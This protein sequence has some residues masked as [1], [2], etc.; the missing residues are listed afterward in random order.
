MG[1]S[2]SRLKDQYKELGEQLGLKYKPGV[3]AIL[4]SEVMK[5]QIVYSSG[6]SMS[7][8]QL[9]SVQKVT[10]IFQNP[11]IKKLLEKLFPGFVTGKY[12]DHEVFIYPKSEGEHSSYHMH[13]VLAFKTPFTLGMSIYTES[14][15][16]RVAKSL[17]KAQDIQ[18][19]N[20][21]LDKLVMIKGKDVP[22]VQA[23]L[24][25]HFRQKQLTGFFRKF[26]SSVMDDFGIQYTESSAIVPAL[27]ATEV[28][29][30]L[31][32]VAE[33]FSR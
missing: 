19:G 12:R 17:F 1:V 27:R 16:S 26:P 33:G 18:S 15:F 31:L 2:L 13:F 28:L 4:S 8:Q 32:S 25:D 21:E 23:L 24:S 6:N 9:Q 7:L 10:E 5:R 30:A 11:L 20:A 14:F 3:D 29:D 22:Q